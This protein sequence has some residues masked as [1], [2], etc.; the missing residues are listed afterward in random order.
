MKGSVL[1][2]F[3]PR[4]LDHQTVVHASLRNHHGQ[5]RLARFLNACED[6]PEKFKPFL[7]PTVGY[8]L[9]QE[10]YY[11]DLY[12]PKNSTGIEDDVRRVE[13]NPEEEITHVPDFCPPIV[14]R[15]LWMAV[16]AVR[17]ERRRRRAARADDAKLMK[18]LVPDLSAKYLLTG[19]ARCGECGASMRPTLS[20]RKSKAGKSYCYYVCPR[21]ID[22][23]CENKQSVPEDWLRAV[24][25]EQ[26][27]AQLF[28]RG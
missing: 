3:S 9:D 28:P 1:K 2:P 4:R 11:G 8:W 21:A 25:V 16:Q 6:I 14:E 20:G 5:T 13:P 26:L 7:G 24:V 22:G 23:I 17:E 10:I 27:R 18:P 15:D 12:W 19:L